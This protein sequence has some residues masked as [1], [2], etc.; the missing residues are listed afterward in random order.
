MSLGG[1]LTAQG[2]YRG[3]VEDGGGFYTYYREDKE[4]DLGAV[5][6]FSGI[7]VGGS[8]EDVTVYEI[9]FFKA[10]N[11][12]TWS[13]DREVETKSLVLSEIPER[14]FSEIVLQVAKATASSTERNENWK[15][16]K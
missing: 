8:N 4:L 3:E 12:S 7:Y 5:I 16:G 2:W 6:N 10:V 13:Y 11:L 15:K 14:Y 9:R 1:K